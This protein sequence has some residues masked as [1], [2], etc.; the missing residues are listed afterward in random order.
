MMYAYSESVSW[1]TGVD[2]STI[3][4]CT[5][6]TVVSLVEVRGEPHPTEDGG[7]HD[8]EHDDHG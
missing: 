3:T 8:A 7:A 5:V 1:S 6:Y 4:C 2:M